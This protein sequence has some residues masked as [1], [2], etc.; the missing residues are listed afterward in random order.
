MRSLARGAKGSRPPCLVWAIVMP[1]IG[2]GQGYSNRVARRLRCDAAGYRQFCSLMSQWTAA[3]VR[4]VCGFGRLRSLR[5]QWR[6]MGLAG[7]GAAWLKSQ[8][9]DG[10]AAC[11]RIGA[12]IHALPRALLR[13]GARLGLLARRGRQAGLNSVPCRSMA[14]MMMARRRASA[15][16]ALRVFERRAMASAQS[17]SFSSPLKRVSKTLAAS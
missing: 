17:F 16:R 11:Y 12:V 15:T 2:D 9:A 10:S 4:A 1:I 6:L 14:C 3:C 5:A 8:S 13:S 7:C